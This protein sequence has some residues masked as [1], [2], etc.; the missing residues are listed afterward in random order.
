MSVRLLRHLYGEV[1][2]SRPIGPATYGHFDLLSVHRGTVW[3]QIFDHEK[4]VLRGGQSVLVYPETWFQ[5]GVIGSVARA[6]IQ[7][8]ALDDPGRLLLP[9]R[10]LCGRKAGAEFYETPPPGWLEQDVDQAIT[11]SREPQTPM[12]QDTRVAHLTFLLGR[13]TL[14]PSPG[15]LVNPEFREWL[16]SRLSSVQIAGMAAHCGLSSSHYRRR[17]REEAGISA[18]LYLQRLRL[19]EACRLLTE[20]LLPIKDISVQVGYAEVPNFHRAFKAHMGVA[21][22]AYRQLHSWPG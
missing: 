4:R 13:V 3:F 8:F 22:N 20:T 5:G 21:P 10:R 11:L 15:K 9:L 12:L 1:N 7:H 6:S 17:F 16:R 2:P 18:G 19:S 14:Q